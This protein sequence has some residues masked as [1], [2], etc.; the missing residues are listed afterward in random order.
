[1]SLFGFLMIKVPKK[2][3]NSRNTNFLQ[4]HD[5]TNT[6]KNK[7]TLILFC[8]FYTFM[9]KKLKNKLKVF[10]FIRVQNQKKLKKN[11]KNNFE[12]QTKHSLKSFVFLFFWFFSSFLVF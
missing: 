3:K 9:S 5:G 10:W 8:F 6:C 7:K 12:F 1:L 4:R 11:K 2:Q